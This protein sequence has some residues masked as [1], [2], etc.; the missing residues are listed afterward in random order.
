MITV[1]GT[2]RQ[3]L[4]QYRICLDLIRQGLLP[5]VNILTAEFGLDGAAEAFDLSVRGTGLKTGFVLG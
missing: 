2:S 4:R 3:N 1:T 5:V